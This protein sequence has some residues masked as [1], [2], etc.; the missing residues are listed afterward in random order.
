[1]KHVTAYAFLAICPKDDKG[2]KMVQHCCKTRSM[3][4]HLIEFACMVA[5]RKHVFA[6]MNQVGWH[7][8]QN[9]VVPRN[10]PIILLAGKCPSET[11]RKKYV[12]HFLRAWLRRVN[13]ECP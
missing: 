11:P 10:I 3:N 6:M 4:L 2:A 12:K 13:R 1:M 7:L 8:C 5:P 9:L